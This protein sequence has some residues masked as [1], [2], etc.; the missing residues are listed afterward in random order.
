MLKI[1][2][3]VFGVY[4]FSSYNLSDIPNTKMGQPPPLP[5]SI[6]GVNL[7]IWVVEAPYDVPFPNLL[8]ISCNFEQ[9]VIIIATLIAP[10]SCKSL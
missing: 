1:R 9:R 5:P 10:L 4:E 8:K 3:K 7:S 6:R 2:N